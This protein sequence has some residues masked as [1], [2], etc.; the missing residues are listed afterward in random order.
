MKPLV[1]RNLR[2]LDNRPAARLDL[3]AKAAKVV[4]LVRHVRPRL[5]SLD[6]FFHAD[7]QFEISRIKPHARALKDRRAVD[8][9]QSEKA[10]VE[11]ARRFEL[12]ARDIDLSMIHADD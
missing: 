9:A 1:I 3:A 6:A 12:L 10:D 4:H 5:A 7:V 11:L 8:L 2:L